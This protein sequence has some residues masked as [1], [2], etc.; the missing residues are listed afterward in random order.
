MKVWVG[1]PDPKN[2]IMLVV[3]A[4]WVVVPMNT[5]P[6]HW[7]SGN[8]GRHVSIGEVDPKK[9]QKG[10]G[11]PIED[12]KILMIEMIIPF[13]T[14]ILRGPYDT[15]SGPVYTLYTLYIYIRKV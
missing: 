4:G 15:Q 3:T 5:S 13:Q 2:D 8:S 12:T 11:I 1:I 7:K 10:Q 14:I 9:A 6:C